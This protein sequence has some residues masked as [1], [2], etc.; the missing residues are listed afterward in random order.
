MLA[1]DEKDAKKIGGKDGYVKIA[2][3]EIDKKFAVYLITHIVTKQDR[4]CSRNES[5]VYLRIRIG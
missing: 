1:I 5:I 2:V 4:V 3:S